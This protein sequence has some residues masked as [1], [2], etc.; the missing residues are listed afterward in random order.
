MTEQEKYAGKIAK[1]L[2]KAESTTPE[3]AEAC[4]AKAQELMTAYAISEALVDKARG[5][6]RDEIGQ[7]EFPFVGI[8]RMATVNIAYGVLAANNCK[9][10]YQENRGGWPE[11][12]TVDGKDYM[13]STIVVGTGFQSD[14][15]RGSLLISSLMVQAVRDLKA[16]ERS[17]SSL[18]WVGR[19]AAYKMKRQFLFSWAATVRARLMEAKRAGEKTAA[20]E[21]AKRARV[22]ADEATESVALVL[23]DRK[24]RVED[25]FDKRY[26]KSLRTVHRN[27]S[28]GGWSAADAGR[29]A[30]SRADIGQPGLGGRG[31][32]PA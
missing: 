25:W 5:V 24:D 15:E 17:E 30:G 6:E 11:T 2:A 9:S 29:A 19:S 10:V 27:Y 4:I 22:A 32:L 8:Y 28:S 3:E 21:E 13:D 31:A 7:R 18:G 12:V 1:L 14:L 20:A 16:W 26:G 23:R